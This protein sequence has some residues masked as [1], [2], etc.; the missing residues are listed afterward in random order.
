[1]K[2]KELLEDL[3]KTLALLEKFEKERGSLRNV[4]L[5][6]SQLSKTLKQIQ[7]KSFD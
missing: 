6:H 1:M 5:Y 3:M 2:E 7:S 4:T